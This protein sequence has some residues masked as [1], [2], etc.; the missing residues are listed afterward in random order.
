MLDH[1]SGQALL[2]KP[3]VSVVIPTLN[4]AKNLPL[5]LS[6]I[7]LDIV[8]EVI[9]V[10]GRSTDNT[11]A[12]AKEL[13]PSV[14]IIL[15][16][17][18]GKGAALRRGYREARGDIIIVLDADGSN[19]PREIPRFVQTLLEGAD[20]AKGSRFAP[21][22]GTSDMPRLRKLGNL[23]FVKIVNL[24]FSQSFTDLCYGFHAFW[25]HSLE[26][27]DLGLLD[28]FEVDT[29]IYLQAVQKK[30]R[31]VDVPSFEGFRFYGQGKLQTFP[32]GWRVLR[33]IFKQWFIGLHNPSVQPRLGFRSYS[34]KPGPRQGSYIPVTGFDINNLKLGS[35]QGVK[36]SYQC[37]GLVSFFKDYWPMIAK[38]ESPQILHNALLTAMEELGASSGSMIVLDRKKRFTNGYR[39]FGRNIA[40]ITSKEI[41]DSLHRGLIGW[42]VKNNQH[43]IVFNTRTDPRWISR[44]W[45]KAEGVSRSVLIVPFNTVGQ[46]LAVLAL[47]RPADRPFTPTDLQRLL[48]IQLSIEEYQ[49]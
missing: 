8:D 30:L 26:Y 23:A 45:E 19:D 20:L 34:R 38:L 4:E 18:P 1:F 3:T 42:A 24:L 43:V 2:R 32:D 28:G 6:Y 49:Q 29:A 31:V 17:T 48:A 27:L 10:D 39:I 21:R 16:Q 41:D 33:T 47:S 35:C 46:S 13:L 5:V 37:A 44:P 36:N 11:I 14:K 22:G 9:I 7:P 40:R 25:R 12:V 15:E